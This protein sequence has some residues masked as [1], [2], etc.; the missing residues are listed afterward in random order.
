[1]VKS[2]ISQDVE[3]RSH[4]ILKYAWHHCLGPCLGAVGVALV[5]LPDGAAVVAVAVGRV[6][7]G[8]ADEPL[9]LPPP[10]AGAVG[11]VVACCCTDG[12]PITTWAAL[13]IGSGRFPE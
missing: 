2:D 13:W 9:S 3:P 1:L 5:L 6:A 10:V 12:A 7:A 8:A 11:R 4:A